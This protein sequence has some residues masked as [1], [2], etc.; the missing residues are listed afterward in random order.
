MNV[1]HISLLHV[2]PLL[3][4]KSTEI[5]KC[6]KFQRVGTHHGRGTV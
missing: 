1:T 4:T 5:E 6:V 3:S 2:S